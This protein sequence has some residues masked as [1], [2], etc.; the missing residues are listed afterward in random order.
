MSQ[1][2]TIRGL[3]EAQQGNLRLIA[4]LRPNGEL[5]QAVRT[6]TIAAQRYAV[7]ETH[8][9]TGA[10]KA[11]HR[12]RMES[13]TGTVYLDPNARNPRTRA[14]TAQYGAVEHAR[15]GEHAFYENTFNRYGDRIADQAIA[16]YVS[17]LS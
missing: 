3:Q 2:I 17:R 9:D 13:L 16:G 14:L 4:S 7:I 1:D 5:S 8:V 15:G 6:G 11:S 12:I 10:L